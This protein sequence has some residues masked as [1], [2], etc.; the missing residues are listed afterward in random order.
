M[1][2]CLVSHKLDIYYEYGSGK[3][4]MVPGSPKPGQQSESSKKTRIAG[5]A[6]G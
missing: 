1:I 5:S 4:N 6:T 2:D 3:T